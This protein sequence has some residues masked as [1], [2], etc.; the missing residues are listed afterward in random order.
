MEFYPANIAS[1]TFFYNSSLFQIFLLL[2]KIFSS[3][4]KCSIISLT[5]SSECGPSKME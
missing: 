4:I 5:F 2:G 3:N 1:E